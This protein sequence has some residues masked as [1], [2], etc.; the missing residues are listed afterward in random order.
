MAERSVVLYIGINL[1][2]FLADRDETLDW[3]L[4]TPGEGD[5]GFGAFLILWIP[6]SWEE[7]LMTGFWSMTAVCHTRTKNVMCIPQNE[8]ADRRI[9]V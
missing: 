1:D 2:G 5:N 6:S 9:C 7:E 8:A 4:Q 3:L